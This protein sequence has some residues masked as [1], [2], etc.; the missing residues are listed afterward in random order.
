MIRIIALVLFVIWLVVPF[1]CLVIQDSCSKKDPKR[2]DIFG[3]GFATFTGVPVL[4]FILYLF[5]L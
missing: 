5:T 4:M 2:D 1:A 3:V